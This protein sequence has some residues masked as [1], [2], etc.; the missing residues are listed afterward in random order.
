MSVDVDVDVEV[1][2][3]CVW[4]GGQA[5]PQDLSGAGEVLDLEALVEVRTVMYTNLLGLTA[6]KK[7]EGGRETERVRS[8]AWGCTED[9]GT[10]SPSTCLV[11]PVPYSTG[12]WMAS[13]SERRGPDRTSPEPK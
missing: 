8:E 5:G 1:W 4:V 2:I 11:R 6:D 12:S 10:P 9:D 13:Q 3:T 7:E